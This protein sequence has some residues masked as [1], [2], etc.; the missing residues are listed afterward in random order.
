MNK[1]D[2][3]QI[4]GRDLERRRKTA[5]LLSPAGDKEKPATLDVK[6]LAGFFAKVARALR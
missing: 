5:I 4:V 3:R 1:A 6:R 2:I